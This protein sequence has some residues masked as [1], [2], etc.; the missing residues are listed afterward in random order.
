M[1]ETEFLPF[2]WNPSALAKVVDSKINVLANSVSVESSL[3]G[4]Q[5]VPSLYVLTWPFSDAYT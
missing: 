2:S 5:V 4:F 1:D 3:P